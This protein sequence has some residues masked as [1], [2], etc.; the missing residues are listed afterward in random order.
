[1]LKAQTCRQPVLR[2]RS[3]SNTSCTME[4]EPHP[5]QYRTTVTSPCG[6]TSCTA[7]GQI[8]QSQA[9]GAVTAGDPHNPFY[10]QY[11]LTGL[12]VG[13]T[14]WLDMAAESIG[15]VSDHGDPEW[16]HWSG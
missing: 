5:N 1:M 4:R 3:A 11:I 7:I 14:Y 15:T 2:Q 12:T 13:T 8:F 6:T 16:I 9:G 10:I